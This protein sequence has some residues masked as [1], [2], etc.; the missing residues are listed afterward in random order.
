MLFTFALFYSA[1]GFLQEKFVLSRP[2]GYIWGDPGWPAITIPYHDMLDFYYSGHI[3]STFMYA[4]ELYQN[5]EMKLFYVAI[6]I[7]LSMWPLLVFV[8]THYWID[9]ITAYIVAH[10][11]IMMSE[12]ICFIT[13]VKLLGSA[14]KARK[15]HA[16]LPCHKCG[17]SNDNYSLAIDK[18]EKEFLE[19]TNRIRNRIK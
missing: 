12:Q 11:C 5:D 17:Y 10:W 14:G 3:G 6:A 9:M 2:F 8:R 19:K 7:H 16:H 15:Q 1:R 18:D 4:C 13:D